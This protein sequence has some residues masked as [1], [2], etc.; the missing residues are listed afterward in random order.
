[1]KH[2]PVAPQPAP[3]LKMGWVDEAIWLLEAWPRVYPPYMGR[4]PLPTPSP[5][6]PLPQHFQVKTSL[7]TSW[8]EE[9]GRGPF[10]YGWPRR[11]G[12]RWEKCL[13]SQ[14]ADRGG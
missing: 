13:K 12:V 14:W 8:C 5:A 3:A 4:S 2:Q 10:Q 11:L 6:C 9:W 1:M 7:R